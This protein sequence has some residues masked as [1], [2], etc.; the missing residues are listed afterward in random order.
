MRR[1][2]ILGVILAVV[3]AYFPWAG[4]ASAATVSVELPTT[5]VYAADAGEANALDV[6]MEGTSIVFHDPAA[7]IVLGDFTQTRYRSATSLIRTGWRATQP[8]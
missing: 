7:I 8:S 5:L 1:A 4:K 3:A 2:M 6:H